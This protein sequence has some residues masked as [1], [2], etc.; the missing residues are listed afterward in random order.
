MGGHKYYWEIVD[1]PDQEAKGRKYSKYFG[2][3]LE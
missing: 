2:L 1:V 3:Q